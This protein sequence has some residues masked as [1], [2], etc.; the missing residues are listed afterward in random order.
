MA[1]MPMLLRAFGRPPSLSH[2][3]LDRPLRAFMRLWYATSPLQVRGIE[4]SLDRVRDTGR[5][6]ILALC[7]SADTL[8][9]IELVEAFVASLGERGRIVRWEDSEHVRHMF[10][11]RQA[12]F[13]AVQALVDEVI[14]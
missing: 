11:H 13:G 5:W 8:I 4:A 2:P 1:M 7:S 12:Y 14:R 6:P 3:R 10:V 9:P